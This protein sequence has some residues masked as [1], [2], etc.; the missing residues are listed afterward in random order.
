MP[1]QDQAIAATHYQIRVRGV[2][3][4]SW[5]ARLGGM[6]IASECCTGQ[7]A[8]TI[9]S[10]ELPDQTK[11]FGILSALYGLGHTILSVRAQQTR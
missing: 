9:L 5:S 4:G 1:A 11:L 3:D 7:T 8:V 2:V 10:G 6:R